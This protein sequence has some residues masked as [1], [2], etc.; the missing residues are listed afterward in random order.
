MY[1][2]KGKKKKEKVSHEKQ[3]CKAPSSIP[4]VSKEDRGALTS[5]P[6]V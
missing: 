1:F 5:P 3:E 6:A 4:K 2:K